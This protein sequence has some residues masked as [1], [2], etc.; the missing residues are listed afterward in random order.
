MHWQE[1]CNV[2]KAIA[3]SGSVVVHLDSAS[4]NDSQSLRSFSSG[5]RIL[6][7]QCITS[8]TRKRSL[9]Y[10]NPDVHLLCWLPIS[11]A[12]KSKVAFLDHDLILVFQLKN[13]VTDK[14][15]ERMREQHKIS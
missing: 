10:R 5:S 9:S 14:V 13:T 4:G 8:G 12:F 2:D 7:L 11:S 15:R 1:M 3:I 6:R